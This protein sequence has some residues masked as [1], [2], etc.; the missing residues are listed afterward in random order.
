MTVH[1]YSRQNIR[2]EEKQ[3]KKEDERVK[4]VA[5]KQA[6]EKKETVK[7]IKQVEKIA[8]QIPKKSKQG[9]TSESRKRQQPQM[10]QDKIIQ[11]GKITKVV[12]S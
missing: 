5:Q 3:R 10:I 12:V 7:V 9:S 11:S 2:R 6:E 8:K 4:K 1:G